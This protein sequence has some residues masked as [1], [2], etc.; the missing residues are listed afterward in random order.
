[1]TTSTKTDLYQ[2]DVRG[3]V[4]K[5]SIEAVDNCLFI[6]YGLMDG[7]RQ[8]NKEYVKQGL[9]SRTLE[10]QVKSRYD[11]RINKQLDRGY[12]YTLEEAQN[13]KGT[14]ALN[15]FKPMLAQPLK[16]VHDIDFT[17]AFLQPKYDGHRCLITN[18]NG[19]TIAYSRQG[20]IIDSITHI[21]EQLDVPEGTVLDGE[22]YCHGVSLQQIGS[23]VK[24]KQDNT[25]QLLYHAYDSMSQAPFAE[26]FE[27]LKRAIASCEFACSAPTERAL[28]QADVRAYYN[29]ARQSGY[30]GAILRWGNAGYGVG[31]RSKNLVKVK[32]TIDEEFHVVDIIASRDG[33]AILVCEATNWK[34]FKVNAPGGYEEKRK[35]LMEKHRYIGKYVTVE[36][37]NL[38][39]DGIPF[40]PVALRWRED[41]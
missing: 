7:A 35:V 15:F 16:K 30:E 22:L 36:Y 23:W 24:R 39:A 3:Q 2:I 1:M 34:E 33:W 25:K 12:K 5:W 11:S 37:A 8:I 27:H 10:E 29:K 18:V 26:R 21:T 13:N 17:S 32:G 40:H 4:R 19:E 41:I 20:K 38:T 6:E 14:N 31:K 28:E 9:A